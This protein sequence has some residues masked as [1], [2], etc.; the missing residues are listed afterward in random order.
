MLQKETLLAMQGV[1]VLMLDSPL[2]GAD[3]VGGCGGHGC[4]QT[5]NCVLLQILPPPPADTNLTTMP[6]EGVPLSPRLEL[7]F[8]NQATL[9]S[10]PG[11]HAPAG[12]P[13]ATHQPH[14]CG[15]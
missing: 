3:A 11:Y 10:M 1:L 13:S 4:W 9:R 8:N 14:M 2:A 12:V 6:D 7:E 15:E 5:H